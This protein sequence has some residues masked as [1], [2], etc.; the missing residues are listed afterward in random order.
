[1]K[2]VCRIVAF[3][4][5]AA[6]AAGMAGCIEPTG[7]PTMPEA[8][9]GFSQADI[10]FAVDQAVGGLAQYSAR[11]D[12]GEG[13]RRVVNVKDVANDTLSRGASAEALSEQL[14]QSLRERLTNDGKFIVYNEAAA[15]MAVAR[16]Q[17]VAVVPEFVLYGKLQQRNMRRDN[18]NVY[19]EFSL[20]LR[21]VDISRSLEVWQTRIPILKAVDRRNAMVN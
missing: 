18:G 10:D 20:N 11:Y 12:A 7:Y 15:R 17:P 2:I 3:A 16:G 8:V 14:G 19:Q 1:M 5:L 13:V 21:L 4:G 6:V 9:A